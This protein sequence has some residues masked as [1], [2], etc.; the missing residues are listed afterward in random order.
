MIT[1]LVWYLGLEIQNN[2]TEL[3]T[4]TNIYYEK[5]T[6]WRVHFLY[7]TDHC[8]CSL[9]IPNGRT[10]LLPLFTAT[11]FDVH[12][13]DTAESLCNTK[14]QYSLKRPVN[15]AP[16]V[17]GVP[18]NLNDD[19]GDEEEYAPLEKQEHNIALL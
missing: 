11:L 18:I 12:A 4:N 7:Y 3:N 2:C 1:L 17:V 10:V 6:L 8:C 9:V 5:S 13:Q 14:Y 16:I 15:Q 19:E